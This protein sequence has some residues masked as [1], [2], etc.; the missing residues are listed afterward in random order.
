MSRGRAPIACGP[1]LH[2]GTYLIGQLP[3]EQRLVNNQVYR[4]AMMHTVSERMDKAHTPSEMDLYRLG[5][6]PEVC[7]TA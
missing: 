1:T 2:K 3:N 7:R 6:R 5:G 4:Q